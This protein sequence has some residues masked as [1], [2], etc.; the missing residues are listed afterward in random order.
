M[1]LKYSVQTAC[2]VKKSAPVVGYRLFQI[3]DAKKYN[4]LLWPMYKVTGTWHPQ[5]KGVHRADRVPN[6]YN[7]NGLY[8]FK[9]LIRTYKH[10]SFPEVLGKVE[11]WGRCVEHADGWRGE[12]ARI[13][14]LYVLD[15]ADIA[16]TCLELNANYR[17]D[18]FPFAG[19][20]APRDV[21]RVRKMFTSDLLPDPLAPLTP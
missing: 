20:P 10:N 2:V 15:N 16:G 17:L 8:M 14:W 3:G 12:Y 1:C 5:P 9:T 13:K 18:V 21:Y 6:P 19:Q 4:S 11:M 7:T